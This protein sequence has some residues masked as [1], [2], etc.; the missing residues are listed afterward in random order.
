LMLPKKPK[1]PWVKA[2]MTLQ[3]TVVVRP[4]HLVPG[5]RQSVIFDVHDER[6]NPISGAAVAVID[7][8]T[9]QVLQMFTTD[10]N[11]RIRDDMP[12]QGRNATVIV[13]IRH[14]S[15]IPIEMNAR[16]LQAGMEYRVT[17]REDLAYN[18][19]DESFRGE[20]FIDWMHRL[21]IRKKISW[22]LVFLTI[23]WLSNLI[24]LTWNDEGVI[25]V[26]GWLGLGVVSGVWTAWMVG[27]FP[28]QR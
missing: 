18:L 1:T 8:R 28:G 23:V 21:R 10:Q 20:R 11:G 24:P 25:R 12:Y 22:T 6:G 3:A 19:P 14:G 13:R 26:I 5:L 17:M 4:E 7:V 27:W 15:H 16:T 9:N 2:G